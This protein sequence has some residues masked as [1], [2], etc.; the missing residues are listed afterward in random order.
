VGA[1]F[2]GGGGIKSPLTTFEPTLNQQRNQH[3]NLRAGGCADAQ[4]AQPAPDDS[5]P[6]DFWARFQDAYP[7]LTRMRATH[8]LLRRIRTEGETSFQDVLDGIAAYIASK[9]PERQWL[10]SDTFLMD[11]RYEDRPAAYRG[12]D[13]PLMGQAGRLAELA[14][15]FRD[16]S[17]GN[18]DDPSGKQQRP[19][20]GYGQRARSNGA[21]GVSW[22]TGDGKEP[23]AEILLIAE[24]RSYRR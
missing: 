16:P 4:P 17:R 10:G 20:S 3:K 1:Q 7:H 5:W 15:S 12:R 19:T 14:E 22:T 23:P 6:D 11:R 2:P 8:E 21:A 13:G 9:P 24:P 18:S